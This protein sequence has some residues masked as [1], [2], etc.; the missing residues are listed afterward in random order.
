M[1]L[2]FLIV[3]LGFLN[4]PARA[5]IALLRKRRSPITKRQQTRLICDFQDHEMLKQYLLLEHLPLVTH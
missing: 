5:A 1:R 3:A 2:L 4:W